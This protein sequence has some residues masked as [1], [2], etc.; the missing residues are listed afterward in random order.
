[1]AGHTPGPWE[2]RPLEYDDW[3]IVRAGRFVICQARDP[4]RMD[5]ECLAY[6]RLAGLDPWRSN[7][8]LIA[9]APELLEACKA[10]MRAHSGPRDNDTEIA[11]WDAAITATEAAIAKAEGK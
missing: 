10:F 7:A 5:G 1:M 8:R 4:E 6:H 2:Y 9:A 3:G 11:L